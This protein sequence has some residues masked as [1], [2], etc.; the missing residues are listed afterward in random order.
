[1]R[2]TKRK[3]TTAILVAS[4]STTSLMTTGCGTVVEDWWNE[5]GD[6]WKALLIGGGA[7]LAAWGLGMDPEEA[8]IV[9][10]AVGAISYGVIKYTNREA[11]QQEEVV[12]EEAYETR[13]ANLTNGERTIA[14]EQGA[15]IA[16]I[17]DQD[18]AAGTV[19]IMLKDPESGEFVD[20]QVYT[21][22]VS[23]LQQS[24]TLADVQEELESKP[25]VTPKQRDALSTKRA[26]ETETTNAPGTE[27]A[28]EVLPEPDAEDIK[29]I[30]I[31]EEPVLLRI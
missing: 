20:D 16:V 24:T 19:D 3:I 27:D 4:I 11:T 30:K 28:P 26:I 7:F 12:A 14:A 8:A 21:L 13:V 22:N 10:A 2:P 29:I 25:N 15:N 9:G 31:D 17:V 23:D 1:M 18:E 5:M 6:G